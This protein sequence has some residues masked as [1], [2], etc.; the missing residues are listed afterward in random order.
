MSWALARIATKCVM[1]DATV[2]VGAPLRLGDV[3][4]GIAWCETCAQRGGYGAPPATLDVPPAPPLPTLRP[5]Q[6]ALFDLEP[7]GPRYRDAEARR[8]FQRLRD[9][10]EPAEDL[11]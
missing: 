9:V 2:P 8:E 10:L 4:P 11:A 3:V 5:P 1:C 7:E 6:G